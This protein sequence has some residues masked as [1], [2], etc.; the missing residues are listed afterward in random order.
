MSPLILLALGAAHAVPSTLPVQGV[1]T[2]N[3]G[4]PVDGEVPVRFSL[5]A[6]PSGEVPVWTSEQTLVFENG[7][8]TAHLGDNTE[9]DLTLFRD[10]GQAWLGMSINEDAETTR[11]RIGATPFAIASGHAEEAATL[12]GLTLDEILDEIPTT[13]QLGD[14]AA[15]VCYDNLAELQADLDAV[16]LTAGYV[17]SW[18]DLSDVPSDLADGDDDTT[19]GVGPGIA[20]DNGAF[21]ID[22]TTLDMWVLET[23]NAPGSLDST[24]Q[25]YLE[26]VYTPSFNDLNDV[27][28]GLD[29]GDDDTIYESGDGITIDDDVVAIDRDL[30]DS[31]ILE[32]AN[33]PGMLDAVLAAYL[34]DVYVP[35]FND[36]IDV[37]NGL[38]DGDDDTRY[39]PGQG[40]TITDEVV[41]IDR[42]TLDAWVLETANQPGMLDNVIAAYLS[43]VYVPSFNELSD[44]PNGLDDGDDDTTYTVGSGLLMDANGNIT[45]DQ[46]TLDDWIL[47]TANTPGVL[48]TVIAA[49]LADR[50]VPDFNELA[51]VPSDL[52]DGD[53]DTTYAAGTGLQL[54]GNTFEVDRATVDSWILATANQPGM[55]DDVIA[56]YLTNTWVTN[57]ENLSGMPDCGPGQALTR[58]ADELGVESWGCAAAVPNGAILFF[59][60][61]CPEGWAEFTDL[62]GRALVGVPSGGTVGGASGSALSDLGARTITDVP[63][64]SHTV[65]PPNTATT[66]NGNHRHGIKTRQDDWNVSGGS[67]P[68]WGGDN[69]SYAVRHYTEYAGTHT[70]NVNIAAFTSGATG[71]GAVD[72]TMPYIQLR[73][74]LAP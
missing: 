50:Y 45:I 22:R 36:L 26:N 17:P 13:D 2:D 63:S 27:P 69:G 66:S 7:F 59:A 56:D 46:V 19:Y 11:I 5:Y 32:T 41:Q 52:A 71:A 74:C 73:A 21:A 25:E 31:W 72:V 12:D 49:Y 42:A 57:V 62:S 64:H 43:D 68:S 16:Y 20:L 18:I 47:S 65:D 61:D 40:I 54:S 4:D 23:T 6:D 37:P 3:V 8:F 24:L 14:I 33:Q 28:E 35:S 34:S 39:T 51:N 58:T 15:G 60:G 55:L 9:L 67:T 30:L 10:L 38:D 29:D 1:I 70:H 48:D 44:V 53:Q